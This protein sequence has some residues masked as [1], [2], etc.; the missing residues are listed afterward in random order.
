MLCRCRLPV[1]FADLRKI[2]DTAKRENCLTISSRYLADSNITLK[3]SFLR[4]I[5]SKVFASL[6]RFYTKIDV[7]DTQCGAKAFPRMYIDKICGQAKLK[8]YAFDVEWLL[9]A[10]EHDI[11]VSEIPVTWTNGTNSHVSV[12]RDSMKMMNDVRKIKKELRIDAKKS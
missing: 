2:I 12:F 1:T 6:L 3:Q 7:K 10:K 11:K 9:R 4:R 5:A 8:G